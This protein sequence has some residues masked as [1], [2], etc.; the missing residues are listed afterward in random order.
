[1]II[2]IIVKQGQKVLKKIPLSEGE[3]LIGREPNCDIQLAGSGVSRR[4]AKLLYHNNKLIVKDLESSNGT[5]LNKQKIGESPAS[6]RDTIQIS[7]YS[8]AFEKTNS[9]KP[10]RKENNQYKPFYSSKFAK[11]PLYLCLAIFLVGLLISGFFLGGNNHRSSDPHFD[12]VFQKVESYRKTG[13]YQLAI[14]ELRK[15]L[16]DHPGNPQLSDLLNELQK[17]AAVEKEILNVVALIDAK[18]YEGL[19]NAETA[20]RALKEKYPDADEIDFW[21]GLAAEEIAKGKISIPSSQENIEELKKG[22]QDVSKTIPKTSKPP[23]KRQRSD[24]PPPSNSNNYGTKAIPAKQPIPDMANQKSTIAASA[25]PPSYGKTAA[26]PNHY[27]EAN[28]ESELSE[29][30]SS[31]KT[32]LTERQK[33]EAEELY[34]QAYK[35]M[36]YKSKTAYLKAL[37]LY[38]KV[39]NTAP[40]KEFEFYRKAEAKIEFIKEQLKTY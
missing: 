22:D 34:Y 39:Q 15:A 40:D 36:A 37:V 23:I 26:S 24:T 30:E 10:G 38:K 16:K 9:D 31:E 7:G 33:E 25:A 17:T 8:L 4:H 1:M 12:I 19:A 28:A 13:N 2:E 29:K 21:L 32:N 14:Q 11:R 3:Y 27:R 6:L 35:I 20:L 5:Y 18:N